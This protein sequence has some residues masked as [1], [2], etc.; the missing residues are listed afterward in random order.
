MALPEPR[1]LDSD[2]AASA[3]GVARRRRDVSVKHVGKYTAGLGTRS[4]HFPAL[5]ESGLPVAE[6]MGALEP[7]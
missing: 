4:R 2:H 1:R 6:P 7:A 5:R 3:P